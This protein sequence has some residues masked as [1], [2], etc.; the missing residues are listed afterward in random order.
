MSLAINSVVIGE[1]KKLVCFPSLTNAVPNGVVSVDKLL[2]SILGTIL[3]THLDLSW[4]SSSQYICPF[5]VAK[6][7]LA[8]SN[9]TVKFSL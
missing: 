5:A 3:Y 4:V 6:N 9:V 2:S 1:S 7:G 8:Q